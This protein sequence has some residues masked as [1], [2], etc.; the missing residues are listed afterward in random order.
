[1]FYQIGFLR[2]TYTVMSLRMLDGEDRRTAKKRGESL[3]E[4]YRKNIPGRS[5]THYADV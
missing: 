5:N 3:E 2:W 4:N 1:M